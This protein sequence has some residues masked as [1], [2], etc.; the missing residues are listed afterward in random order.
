[1]ARKNPD[2][3]MVMQPAADHRTVA[4]QMLPAM[5]VA[6]SETMKGPARK[7]AAKR[8]STRTEAMQIAKANIT[9]RNSLK[10]QRQAQKKSGEVIGPD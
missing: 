10:K 7:S 1:M 4:T 9:R 3:P 8:P 2:M 5:P 6:G